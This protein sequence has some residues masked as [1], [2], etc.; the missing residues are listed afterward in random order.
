MPAT[1]ASSPNATLPVVYSKKY[2]RWPERSNEIF[3]SEKVEKVV[4]PPQMPV[5]KKSF[6]PGWSN[7]PFSNSPKNTPM[8][9]QPRIFTNMVPMGKAD[10]CSLYET[11]CKPYRSTPPKPLPAATNNIAFT[12]GL[13]YLMN[14]FKVYLP[15]VINLYNFYGSGIFYFKGVGVP[16]IDG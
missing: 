7:W 13:V 4:K 3:S 2:S 9:R 1:V 8:A 6:V 10:G 11:V 12:T 5:I 16:V 14:V 15:L